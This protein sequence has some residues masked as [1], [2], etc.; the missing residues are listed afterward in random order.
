LDPQLGRW[1]QI[2]PKPNDAESPY[3]SMGNNPIL[4][5]DPLGDSSVYDNQGNT[6]YYDKKDK[7]L[8]VF[9]KDGNELVNIGQLGGEIKA[10]RML[11]NKLKA[12]AK[13]AMG[14]ELGDWKKMVQK[15][16]GWDLKNNKNTIFGIAWA[17]DEASG[18]KAKNGKETT[19]KY[20][21]LKMNAADVGNY[22]AGY[23]G[24]FAE[25]GSGLQKLGAGVVELLKNGDYGNLLNPA[26]YLSAPYGDNPVDYTYN[27]LGIDQ[28]KA[29]LNNFKKTQNTPFVG[30]HISNA[31]LYGNW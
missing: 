16:G 29:D 9:M 24:S 27:S 5:N 23:T 1:W 25:I 28:G 15:N 10:N 14:M 2:D 31:V 3:A 12:D 17:F 30:S 26:T 20:G 22:H 6:I 11:G 19:F 8:R 4:R 21:S 7:D 13:V 18:K